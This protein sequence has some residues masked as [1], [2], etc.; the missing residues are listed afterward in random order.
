MRQGIFA[1]LFK[2]SEAERIGE[3]ESASNDTLTNVIE[4][5]AIGV[6]RRVRFFPAADVSDESQ[7][8]MNA[9]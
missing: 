3:G 4:T 1:N 2:E 6:H 7:P 8:P 9:N 5:F